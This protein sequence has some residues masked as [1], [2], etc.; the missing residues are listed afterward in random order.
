[1]QVKYGVFVAENATIIII[2]SLRK[3]VSHLKAGASGCLLLSYI[4]PRKHTANFPKPNT[5]ISDD[6]LSHIQYC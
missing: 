3:N 6:T 5:C 1:M 4:K 2:I